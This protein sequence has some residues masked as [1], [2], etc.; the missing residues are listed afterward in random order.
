MIDPPLAMTIETGTV[1]MTIETSIDSTGQGPIPT[2]INTGVTVRV[3]HEGAPPGHNTDLHITTHHATETQAHI[4]T[5]KTLHIE[6]PHYT[7][8]FAGIAVD[9]DHIHHTKNT[10]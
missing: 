10:A 9:P 4:A 5:N 1:V 2:V 7:E 3:I 8:V 6:G